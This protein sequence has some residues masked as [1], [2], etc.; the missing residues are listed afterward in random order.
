MVAVRA[1]DMLVCAG[2]VLTT[3][4]RVEYSRVICEY[5]YISACVLARQC[6]QRRKA[7]LCGQG[8]GVSYWE[9]HLIEG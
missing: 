9:H 5:T 7:R 6:H 3:E 2:S 1:A 4:N 8:N